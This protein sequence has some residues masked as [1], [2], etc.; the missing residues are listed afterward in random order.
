MEWTF[1]PNRSGR[2]EAV[3]CKNAKVPMLK[4][5]RRKG[6][7]KQRF[8]LKG[9]QG[10]G[11][12]PQK[13]KTVNK[14]AE[15]GIQGFPGDLFLEHSGLNVRKMRKSKQGRLLFENIRQRREAGRLQI[16]LFVRGNRAVWWSEGN[17]E[18]LS[19][20]G[21]LGSSQMHWGQCF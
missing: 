7:Q 2:R 10:P 8:E 14:H 18:P 4:G 1:G 13:G 16:A 11:E 6:S 3:S 15:S 5:E 20:R 21:T 19:D 12:F 9:L 17:Q